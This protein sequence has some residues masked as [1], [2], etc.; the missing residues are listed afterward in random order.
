MQ[1]VSLDG[2]GPFTRKSGNGEGGISYGSFEVKGDS[3]Q[4][5]VQNFHRLSDKA[6]CLSVGQP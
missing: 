4:L 2:V 5:E 6:E 1:S 3:Q